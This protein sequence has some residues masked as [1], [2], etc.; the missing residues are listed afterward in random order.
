MRC[1]LKLF[2][3]ILLTFFSWPLMAAQNPIAWTVSKAFPTNVTAGSF[4]NVIYTFTNQLPLQ[5]V[6]PLVIEKNSTPANEFSFSDNCSG[7]Q[8]LPKQTCTVIVTLTPVLNGTKKTQLTIA[9]YNNDRV[10]LPEL[11]AQLGGG[12][13]GGLGN[14]Y[15]TVTQSLPN[16]INV[17]TSAPFTFVF[18]NNSKVDATNVSVVMSDT[19]ATTTCTS[20]LA[21]GKTC[22]VSGSYLPASASPAIQFTTATF[23]YKQG[24]AVTVSTGSNITSLTGVVATLVV[25]DYLPP[26]MVG[27]GAPLPIGVRFTNYGPGAVTFGPTD[28]TV[29]ITTGSGATLGTPSSS[30][31]NGLPA[32]GSVAP[33]CIITT[34]FSAPT[35][36]TPTPFVITGNLNYNGSSS[37][38]VVTSTNVVAT[39]GTSRLI[40][41]QNK[42]GFPVWFSLN[43]GALG[44]SPT[45]NSS[46]DCPTGTSCNTSNKTCFWQ[47]I[48]PTNNTYKIAAY[49]GTGT[50]PSNTV[51]IP[52][53]GAD[54]TIQWSGAMSAS[55]NCDG[56]TNCGL[57]SCG[58]SGGSTACAPGLGYSQ[59]ATEAE[60]T[61]ELNTSDSYDVE[62]I[63]GF[64]IPISMEPGPVSYVTPSNY[65][66][67][68]PGSATV[69]SG[70][71]F[72]QCHF[73]PLPVAPPS[74]A[75]YKVSTS[76]TTCTIGATNTCTGGLQCGLDSALQPVCGQFLGYWT[77]DQA[78]GM[79]ATAANPYF[80]CNTQLSTLS[81][82]F[83]ANDT[84]EKLMLCSVPKGDT[85]PLYNSCYLG[86]TAGTS[87]TC[88]GCVD[89]WQDGIGANSTAQSCTNLSTGLQTDAV[90]NSHIQTQVQWLKNAC[91]SE[92]VYPFDDKTSGFSCTNNLPGASN[93]QDYLITFCP[94][95]IAD[96]GLPAGI[97]EGRDQFP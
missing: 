57:A 9:G 3:I 63:N 79:N 45:C 21:A 55:L 27:G 39:L 1:N 92:Y 67:G 31:T 86:Y 47:N 84:L 88:C 29:T 37:A 13:S 73:T 7:K 35:E 6:K 93:S 82:L 64:H 24:S 16:T 96:T 94:G 26:V 59:P 40:T 75:Y 53:T 41:F 43:G 48:A 46:A 50:A 25:P 42:C 69:S 23:N 14:V 51:T 54:S 44:N 85:G 5:L 33:A 91:P 22:S 4:Y 72:G 58:N 17:A 78:C 12:G 60:V 71:G 18:T 76:S 80:G 30:C 68:A 70:T 62:V 38:S 32:P 65:S 74:T 90:W 77:A 8:L 83:P 49:S 11:T 97:T 15:G 19:A 36:T 56:S 95:G 89:W 52:A 10:P 81:T 34:T 28:G 61:L 87:G 2:F 66:C 20:T